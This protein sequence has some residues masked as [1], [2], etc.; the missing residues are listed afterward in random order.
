[1]NPFNHS[2]KG[3]ELKRLLFMLS[4]LTFANATEQTDTIVNTTNSDMLC[5]ARYP[6]IYD[7]K[8]I[9]GRKRRTIIAPREEVT[10]ILKPGERFKKKREGYA[11]CFNKTMYIK[12]RNSN[13]MEVSNE[14]NIKAFLTNHDT[15]DLTVYEGKTRED[16]DKTLGIPKACGKYKDGE[17]CNQAFGLDIFYDKNNKVK[18]IYLYGNTVH[19]GKLPFKPESILKLR[20]NE[21]P[22]GLWVQKN[23]K[24]LF[25]KK[26]SHYS[27]NLI[28]W[29]DLTEHIKQV[30]ITPKNGHFERSRKMKNGYNL[31]RN[32]WSESGEAP[33]DYI[34]AI[35]VEYR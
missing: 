30:T 29:T 34:Q 26:P 35:E 3:A 16:V 7:I 9:N 17:Y 24:K 14:H 8:E 5:V 6:S 28:V 33:V 23:Y 2:T 21:G 27:K 1:M 15:Y 20:N 18:N 32:D 19:R 4:I 31:F 10:A 25:S 13:R 12:S 11:Y 22:L